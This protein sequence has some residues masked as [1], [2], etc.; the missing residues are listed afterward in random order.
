MRIKLSSVLVDD[1]AKALRFYTSVFMVVAMIGVAASA[2]QAAEVVVQNDSLIAGAGGVIQAGFDPGESAAAW[3]TSPCNGNIVAAQVF[4]RSLTGT[5]PQSIEE[6]ITI[7]DG[8]VF[9]LP[10]TLLASIEG[11][12]MT[13]SVINEFRYLDENLTIPLIVP[14]TTGQTFV[15]SFKFLNDPSPSVGPSLVNDVDGCQGGRNTIDAVGLGWVSSCLLGVTGDWVIRAVV[16][17]QAVVSGPGSVPNGGDTLGQPLRIARVAG[18][19]LMLTWDESC[20]TS[21]DDY[22]IY[23]G[24]MGAY[25]SHFSKLCSTGG[26]TTA[27]FSPDMFDRYYLVVPRDGTQEGSYG[28]DSARDERPQGGGACLGQGTVT[29]PT[30]P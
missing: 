21:D 16:D 1:Q 18:G 8:G 2:A 30:I 24:F 27:T 22:E 20:S 29:C 10:G 19:Q 3:L 25:Y 26:A 9:P 15:V 13:D 7:F 28:R 11:P 17:C 14:V 6:S 23:H 4:W 5:E 12:F